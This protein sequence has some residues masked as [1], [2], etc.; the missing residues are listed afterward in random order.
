MYSAKKKCHDLKTQQ[1]KYFIFQGTF[2]SV[3]CD[4]FNNIFCVSS[5]YK[6]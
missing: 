1:K 3:N 6:I 4:V 2:I 5:L